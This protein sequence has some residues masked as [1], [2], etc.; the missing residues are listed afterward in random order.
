M[1]RRNL[2]IKGISLILGVAMAL[3]CIMPDGIKGDNTVYAA[4]TE[5][6]GSDKF[7]DVSELNSC[8]CRV[9]TGCIPRKLLQ[10]KQ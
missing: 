3:S 7:I 1:R 2:F 6:Q 9:M 5:V 10:A 8:M 4:N